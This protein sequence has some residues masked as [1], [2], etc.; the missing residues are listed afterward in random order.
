MEPSIASCASRIPS[1]MVAPWLMIA[2]V[3]SVALMFPPLISRKCVF[4]ASNAFFTSSS[5]LLM[6]PTVAMAKFPKCERTSSGCG[7]LSEMHPMPSLPFIS[8]KSRSNFVRKGE[9]SIL[10]MARSNPPS[11]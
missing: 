6:R 9:F 2:A 11:P 7:S 8:S 4:P 3:S 5:I 1:G 10:W